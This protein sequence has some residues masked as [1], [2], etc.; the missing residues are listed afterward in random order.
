MLCFFTLFFNLVEKSYRLKKV[1]LCICAYVF[2][3]IFLLKFK[4]GN[5]DD[6]VRAG[7]VQPFSQDISRSTTPIGS[8]LADT[9][10]TSGSCSVLDLRSY[11]ASGISE[12]LKMK[13]TTPSMASSHLSSVISEEDNSG[14]CLVSDFFYWENYLLKIIL[15]HYRLLPWRGGKQRLWLLNWSHLVKW[16]QE[17]VVRSTLSVHFARYLIMCLWSCFACSLRLVIADAFSFQIN[18]LVRMRHCRM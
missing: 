8:I 13:Q 15:S 12:T 3:S 11:P 14:P 9:N 17:P 5:L 16:P 1:S 4:L 6:Y 7:I 10:T 18:V 2:N